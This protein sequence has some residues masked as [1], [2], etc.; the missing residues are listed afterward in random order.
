MP[1]SGSA[2][3]A[4]VFAVET[5]DKGFAV[6]RDG[7]VIVT[8]AGRDMV[9]PTKGL[10]E[11]LA[12][13]WRAQGAKINPAAMPMNQLACTAIDLVAPERNKIIGGVV[14]AIHSDALCHFADE[15]A[16]LV[17]EQEKLWRLYLTEAEKTYGVPLKTGTGIMPIQQAPETVTAMRQALS[18]YDPFRLTGLQQAVSLTGSLVL[19]LALASRRAPTDDILAAAELETLYQTRQWGEDPVTE[20]RLGSL[21]RELEDCQKW[22]RLLLPEA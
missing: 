12:E 10:A 5:R 19:G 8:P 18:D 13:E 1:A 15:P 3:P 11:A 22:F 4:S 6:T 16:D 2:K 21:K 9:V 20:A 17:A 14:S 7:K